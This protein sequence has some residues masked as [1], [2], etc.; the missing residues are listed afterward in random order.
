MIQIKT[1][2]RSKLRNNELLTFYTEVREAINT[3]DPGAEKLNIQALFAP[4]EAAIEAYSAA[5]TALALEEWIENLSSANTDV[6]T[7]TARIKHY[8]DVLAQRQ[9]KSEAK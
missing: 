8:Q 6:Q 3:A 9:G 2:N 5:L 4:F 7:L 1:L